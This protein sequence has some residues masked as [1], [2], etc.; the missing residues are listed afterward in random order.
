M[1]RQKHDYEVCLTPHI[2]FYPMD[3]PQCEWKQ[4]QYDCIA[5]RNDYIIKLQNLL[6]ILFQIFWLEDKRCSFG[7]QLQLCLGCHLQ[8][9]ILYLKIY[10]K[11]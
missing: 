7:Y 3:I 1:Q 10:I 4:I 9:K 11:I 2:E 6:V 8:I 5:L